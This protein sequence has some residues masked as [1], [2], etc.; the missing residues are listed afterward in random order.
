MTK[1]E[2]TWAERVRRW[3]GSGKTAEEF[4]RPEGFAAS[5]LRYWASRLN[6]VAAARKEAPAGPR[7]V[8]V[9]RSRA[10]TAG[11]PLVVTVGAARVEVASGFDRATLASV[12][13]V[14][15]A[16]GGAR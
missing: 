13:E 2:A 3:R 9:E 12:L 16:R 8:R 6:Q 14:L 4:S 1:T 15:G 5:T 7:M 11:A 10:S